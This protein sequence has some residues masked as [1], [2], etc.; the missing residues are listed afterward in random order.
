MVKR[1][2]AIDGA[3]NGE[4]ASQRHLKSDFDSARAGGNDDD[5]S[6][7]DSEFEERKQK[8]YQI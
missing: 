6:S 7:S 5:R 8:E 2:G 4:Y 1:F 3:Q